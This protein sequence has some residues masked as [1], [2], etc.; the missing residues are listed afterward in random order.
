MLLGYYEI[1]WRVLQLLSREYGDW[2]INSVPSNWRN[3]CKPKSRSK[4][5]LSIRTIMLWGKEKHWFWHHS[6]SGQARVLGVC[7]KEIKSETVRT[8]KLCGC[9]ASLQSVVASLESH[10][11]SLSILAFLLCWQKKQIMWGSIFPYWHTWIEVMPSPPPVPFTRARSECRVSIYKPDVTHLVRQQ[12][13]S[14]HPSESPIIHTSNHDW[15]PMVR[16]K[17]H[18]TR[19]P[20]Y[21]VRPWRH[22]RQIR[23]TSLEISHSSKPHITTAPGCQT[24]QKTKANSALRSTLDSRGQAAGRD[25]SPSPWGLQSFPSVRTLAHRIRL[26]PDCWFFKN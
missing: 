5:C 16:H 1:H 14:S 26:Y 24:T 8:V 6:Y 21:P 9:F 20:A 10:L 25:L 22:N 23:Q 3:I 15:R 19:W 7:N 18:P 11:P 2:M 17:P 13:K 12:G 4:N